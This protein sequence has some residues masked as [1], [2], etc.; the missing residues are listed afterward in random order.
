MTLEYALRTDAVR[1]SDPFMKKTLVVVPHYGS[2][3]LLADLFASIGVVFS[4]V[5]L[6][7]ELTSFES[8][9][10]D[11]LLL[12]VNNNAL[13]RGFTAACNL[14]LA[15]LDGSHR[16]VWFLNNDTVFDSPAQFYQSLHRMQQL[17][18][19]RGWALVGQ[20]VRNYSFPDQIVFGG[21]RACFPAGQHKSG[22]CRCGDWQSPE[23][24]AW[25]SFCSVLLKAEVVDQIG[26]LDESFF[27]GII[28]KR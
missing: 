1:G 21:A 3:L 6:G 17:S 14:G 28:N 15:H 20:Q 27:K 18:E 9:D 13:N 10:Q 22:S 2:D 8:A 5:R 19:E 11:V 25:L 16:F 26:R 23:P 7:S 12:V 4:S 24:Q